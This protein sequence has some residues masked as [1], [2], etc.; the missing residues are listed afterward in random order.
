MNLAFSLLPSFS[1][2]VTGS[3][4]VLSVRQAMIEEHELEQRFYPLDAFNL[5]N[6]L[7]YTIP[8]PSLETTSYFLPILRSFDPWPML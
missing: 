7:R 5:F 8:K 2:S 4:L 6:L 1:I 3:C